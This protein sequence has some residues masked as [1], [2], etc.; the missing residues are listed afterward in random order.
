MFTVATVFSSDELPP[1]W[2]QVVSIAAAAAMLGIIMS[3]VARRF[4]SFAKLSD[5]IFAGLQFDDPESVDLPKR[6]SAISSELSPEERKLY[7]PW[8]RWVYKY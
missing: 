4:F 6:L 1:W 7:H 3:L 2:F 5:Q 8:S